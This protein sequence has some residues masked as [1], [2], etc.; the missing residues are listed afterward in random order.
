MCKLGVVGA[1]A[2]V[3]SNGDAE[4]RTVDAEGRIQTTAAEREGE[5]V[6]RRAEFRHGGNVSDA[7]EIAARDPGCMKG[8]GDIA[9]K[10]LERL[11]VDLV[12][13][14]IVVL[15]GRRHGYRGGQ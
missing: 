13:S 1:A 4:R 5:L 7:A 9:V 3:I 8:G 15:V 10:V 14:I 2:L 6:E 11:L 12:G